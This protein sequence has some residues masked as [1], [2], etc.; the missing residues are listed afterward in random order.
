M[1]SQWSPVS[2]GTILG[3]NVSVLFFSE[4][5]TMDVALSGQWSGMPS[6]SLISIFLYLDKSVYCLNLTSQW[7][8]VSKSTILGRNASVFIF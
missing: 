5:V 7:S 2:K 6:F 3:R 1:T 8:Q 4:L